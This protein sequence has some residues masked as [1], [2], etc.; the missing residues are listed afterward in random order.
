MPFRTRVRTRASFFMLK[1]QFAKIG[2]VVLFGLLFVSLSLNLILYAQGREY[3][4]ELNRTRLDP[5]GLAS[6]PTLTLPRTTFA[7]KHRVL[8]FGDSRAA[9]WTIPTEAA[10]LTLFNRGIGSQTSAQAVGRFSS[11]VL[12]LQPDIIVI[13]I[14]I[15]DLKT[16]PLFPEQKATIIANCK[17]NISR[18]VELSVQSGAQVILTTIFPLGRLPVE[19][20]PFW[21]EDVEIAIED[22]NQF[23]T[24]LESDHVKVFD[25]AKVLANASGITD[26]QYSQDF[27][28]LN[29]EGYN[30]LNRELVPLL[31]P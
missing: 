23:I 13:Q 28:H 31:R 22:V 20:R 15:N 25:T 4:L 5:L 11:H 27:L 2:F 7:E 21:S 30:A 1:N 19:R 6:Y 12:P 3:Y 10:E 18:L 17:A 8:F 9:A 14:G 26:S 16:I 24:T 29:A